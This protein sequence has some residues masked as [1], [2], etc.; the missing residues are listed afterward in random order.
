MLGDTMLLETE[1]WA[2]KAVLLKGW[3]DDRELQTRCML[4]CLLFGAER[5]VFGSLKESV[6]STWLQCACRAT[7]ALHD[8]ELLRA[9][10]ARGIVDLLLGWRRDGRA[11]RLFDADTHGSLRG[12]Y[13]STLGSLLRGGMLSLKR[14]GDDAPGSGWAATCVP[15]AVDAILDVG[16]LRGCGT[17][18]LIEGRAAL[19]RASL[20][21]LDAVFEGASW[22]EWEQRIAQLSGQV[23]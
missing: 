14:A 5:A 13:V 9:E 10:E 15:A 22:G 18:V 1:L 21:A 8:L 7:R 17:R 23:H 19:S 2:G 4:A 16:D 6:D 20:A 12:E 11:W 3:R